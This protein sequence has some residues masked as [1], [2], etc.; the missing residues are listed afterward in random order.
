MTDD[1]YAIM[2]LTSRFAQAVD[3][4]DWDEVAR[5]FT[6][7]AVIDYSNGAH[8]DGPEAMVQLLRGVLDHA[9][10]SQHLVGNFVID[11][12]RDRA[13]ANCSIRAFISAAPNGLVPDA[14]YEI[15]AIY[16][17]ELVKSENGWH[18]ARRR[19]DIVHERGDRRV[20]GP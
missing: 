15:F 7:D 13:R 2:E 3:A 17:D 5:V 16:H 1:R 8:A 14:A 12:D 19:A 10:P 20:L 6:P 11:V 4:H 9:G 18:V